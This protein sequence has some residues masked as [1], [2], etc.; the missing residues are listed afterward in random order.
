MENI[1][2]SMRKRFTLIDFL[3]M[4]P[5]LTALLLALLR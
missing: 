4:I 5:A 1:E 3:L 2:L